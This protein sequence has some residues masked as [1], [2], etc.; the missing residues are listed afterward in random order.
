MADA[1]NIAQ[2]WVRSNSGESGSN[3]AS[4]T[5]ASSAN[6]AAKKLQVAEHR[7]GREEL[8]HLF[9]EDTLIPPEMPNL[10]S[11]YQ[12]QL[13]MPL[14]SMLLTEDEQLALST[15]VNSEMAQ[16]LT[17]PQAGW[18][19]GAYRGGGGGRGGRG[20]G[21]GEGAY[22][23]NSNSSYE[24]AVDRGWGGGG[25]GGG[26]EGWGSQPARGK[27][28]RD[29]NWRS[30]SQSEDDQDKGERW[31]TVPS[32]SEKHHHHRA[33]W[34]N[35]KKE[36]REKDSRWMPAWATEGNEPKKPQPSEH[37][38]NKPN[39][40]PGAPEKPKPPS[41]D[42]GPDL[43]SPEEPSKQTSAQTSTKH[44]SKHSDRQDDAPPPSSRPPH[45]QTLSVTRTM[46]P[47]PT[48]VETPPPAPP[49]I[50]SPDSVFLAS[51]SGEEEDPMVAVHLE[52]AAE[53][54]LST[55]EE[56]ASPSPDLADFSKWYYTDP[57][58]EIQGPFATEDMK[59]WYDAGYFTMDLRVRRACD[60]FMLSLGH[61]GQ[62]WGFFPFTPGCR[63]QPPIQ[64][65]EPQWMLLPQ[66][67]QQHFIQQQAMFGQQY[68]LLVPPI[69]SPLQSQVPLA[70][71]ESG[72]SARP[73]V[74][75]GNATPAAVSKQD[76]WPDVSSMQQ[77]SI[78]DAPRSKPSTSAGGNGGPS[79]SK[80]STSAG[81]NGGPSGSKPSISAGG[82]GGP[83]G[84]KPSTSAGGNGGPSG[85]KPSISA[86]GNG[87]PS[88]KLPGEKEQH[89]KPLSVTKLE[90][91]MVREED[92]KAQELKRKEEERLIEQKLAEEVRRNNLEEKARQ[93]Q[94]ERQ[95]DAEE[96]D[97]VL[98]RQD[99]KGREAEEKARQQEEARRK[100]EEARRREEE[101]RHREEEAR[102]K[103]EEARRKK[104]EARR[105]EE[106]ARRRE[107][108]ARRKEEEARRKEEEARR[109]EE[110]RAAR[111]KQQ[112]AEEQK[113]RLEEMKRV[114][115]KEQEE[116]NKLLQ[117][118]EEQA[119]EEEAR[120][121]Q[122]RRHQQQQQQAAP[123]THPQGR[124]GAPS[125]K[126]IQQE[127][128]YIQAVEELQ[129]E[130]VMKVQVKQQQQ[131]QQQAGWKSVSAKP[132]SFL[133]IQQEQQK[134]PAAQRSKNSSNWSAVTSVKQ[135]PP[136][137]TPQAN[138]QSTAAM[139]FVDDDAAEPS[140]FWEEC[141]RVA[142]KDQP[143]APPT[144]APGGKKAEGERVSQPKA[145]P[146]K[147][148]SNP[149]GG[150]PK[151]VTAEKDEEK[152]RR[153]FSV[154]TS[155]SSSTEFN[156]WCEQELKKFDTDVEADAFI[157]LLVALDNTQ[158]VQ[159]YIKS[160]LGETRDA[161]TFAKQFLEKRQKLKTSQPPQAPLSSSPKVS[162]PRDKSTTTTTP[163][164]MPSALP[165]QAGSAKSKVPP[166]QAAQLEEEGGK[167]GGGG[168][169]KKKN[170]MQKVNPSD[171]LGFTVTA[172]DRPNLGG[173]MHSVRDAI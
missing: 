86:G 33:D 21:R 151:K 85:S 144:V 75:V 37:P 140:T 112:Q 43:S 26:A 110:V 50:T 100:E 22:H 162:G 158:E 80:P 29:G 39:K 3:G 108:E 67:Q 36:N 1:T 156:G 143:K 13:I 32:H 109:E 154:N 49:R 70:A 101:A 124:G 146:P 114:K 149:S 129:H 6:N 157:S 47:S 45:P 83:S 159:D 132:K 28:S 172:P 131:Q 142:K 81:G 42:K 54:L 62:V 64:I 63:Q 111:E 102:R 166:L 104:E 48:V 137:W 96:W 160:Y 15:G 59:E 76:Q 113:R 165:A 122:E 11:I 57:Q 123:W 12:T 10:P 90:E 27:G 98:S 58:G 41:S 8:L 167:G 78:W 82:N 31:Q 73:K 107:E 44:L 164:T 69:L 134:D 87:G 7:Y 2:E 139:K 20:R 161:Q 35:P 97:R 152:L 169:K 118:M 130:E 88:G 153:L 93:L 163:L 14:S 56:E 99:S 173:E 117:K 25:G 60:P 116:E 105:K 65:S 30:H 126:T 147:V 84:S 19:G 125:L 18:G 136:S 34:K 135:S 92:R 89:Q 138:L 120:V 79:G 171:L 53:A 91:K 72:W 51:G 5:A 66:Q 46:V 119:K 103:E 77:E 23:R 9:S 71:A 128:E 94:E 141:A 17:S 52:K 168:K 150:P 55:E 127:E 115:L 38:E 106:E 121:A 170:K 145:A 24:E 74:A 133:E 61:I 16:S 68:P 4:K 155:S 95:R 40:A 148:S